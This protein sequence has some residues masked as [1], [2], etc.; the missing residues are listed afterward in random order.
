[1]RV[2]GSLAILLLVGQVWAQDTR[3]RIE[4]SG[5]EKTDS[6]SVAEFSEVE[7]EAIGKVKITIGDSFDVQVSA[8]ENVLPQV[9]TEVVDGRLKLSLREGI[10]LPKNTDIRFAITLP[11][12]AR[13]VVSGAGD[14]HVAGDLGDSLALE[15]SGAG[16]IHAEGEVDRLEGNISGAG[17]L[18]LSKLNSTTAVIRISGTGNAQVYAVE[19]LDAKISGVGN[20]RYQGTAKVQGKVS[21]IGHV[22]KAAKDDAEADSVK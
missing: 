10:I 18:E 7:L 20:V 13:A 5:V 11:K 12:L 14:I 2:L 21:G 6:R 19:N 17:N 4:A 3:E 9:T 8:D 15:I 1:M 16:S 22:S